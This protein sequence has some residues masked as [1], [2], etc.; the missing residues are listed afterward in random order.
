MQKLQF[1]DIQLR[2]VLVVM[3]NGE[4][5]SWINHILLKIGMHVSLDWKLL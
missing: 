2:K 1:V 3:K 4:I 5:L